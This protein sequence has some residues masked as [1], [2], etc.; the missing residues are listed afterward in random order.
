MIGL[1]GLDKVDIRMGKD[2]EWSNGVI[3]ASSYES[4]GH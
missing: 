4:R 3:G 1:F 2:V